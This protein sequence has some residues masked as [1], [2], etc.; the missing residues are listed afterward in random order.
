MKEEEEIDREIEKMRNKMRKEEEKEEQEQAVDENEEEE[1]EVESVG[2]V[3]RMKNFLTGFSG[4]VMCKKNLI[5][6]L[7]GMV[8]TK[9]IRERIG[10]SELSFFDRLRLRDF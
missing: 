4:T 1:Q 2:L 10:V 7:S 6:I 3:Q 5:G 8:C 9:N